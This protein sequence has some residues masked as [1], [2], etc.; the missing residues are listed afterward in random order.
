MIAELT[1]RRYDPEDLLSMRGARFDLVKGRL[2]ERHMGQLANV[3]G[4]R[5]GVFMDHH[6]NA[7]KLGMVFGVPTGYQIFPD[8]PKRVRFPDGSFIRK[9]R[10][11]HGIPFSGHCRIVPD[12]VYEVVSPHDTVEEI[13]ARVMDYLSVSVAIVWVIY[14]ETRTVN[15]YR[16]DGTGGW[17]T[18][19]GELSGE[20]V[21]PGFTCRVAELFEG[22]V[23]SQDTNGSTINGST[24]N[25]PTTS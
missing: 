2:V 12:V 25:G 11:P 23:Q 19:D 22:L 1:E 5:L 21:I 6:V 4:F 3:L 9:G 20:D 16:N 15:I 17:L 18:F 13:Q 14:P 10:L 7:N 8:D 24:T